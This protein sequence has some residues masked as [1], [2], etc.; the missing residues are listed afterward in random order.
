MRRRE[1]E[2]GSGDLFVWGETGLETASSP[3]QP[4]EPDVE[5]TWQPE[6]AFPSFEIEFEEVPTMPRRDVSAISSVRT[7]ITAMTPKS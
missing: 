4:A 2:V 7:R 6:G 3:A 5:E 1:D